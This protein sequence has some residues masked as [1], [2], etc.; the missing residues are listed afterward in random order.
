M[1]T[2]DCPECGRPLETRNFEEYGYPE[3]HCRCGTSYYWPEV[4]DQGWY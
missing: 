4:E 2:I 3:A 1:T